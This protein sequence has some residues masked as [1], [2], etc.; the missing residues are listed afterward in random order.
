M[1]EEKIDPS[2]PGSCVSLSLMAIP[3]QYTILYYVAVFTVCIQGFPFF[4]LLTSYLIFSRLKQN[5]K[6]EQ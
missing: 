2:C 6:L 4:F 3:V 1:S 5:K